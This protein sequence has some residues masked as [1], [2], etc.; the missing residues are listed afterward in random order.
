MDGNGEMAI[1]G[2]FCGWE[3][4][5]CVCVCLWLE[6]DGGGGFFMSNGNPFSKMTF[7]VYGIYTG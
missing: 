1:F 2:F 4:L 7:G 6:E 3:V 5:V